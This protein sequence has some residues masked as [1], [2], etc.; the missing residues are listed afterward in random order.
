MILTYTLLQYTW[1][2]IDVITQLTAKLLLLRTA[3][4][5]WFWWDMI[6]KNSD[7]IDDDNSILLAY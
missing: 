4:F 3:A 6:E 2:E 5:L 7:L 1:I